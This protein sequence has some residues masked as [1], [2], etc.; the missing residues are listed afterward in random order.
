MLSAM[1]TTVTLDPDAE[2]LVRRRM[3]E[4]KVSFKQA[5]NDCI[6]EGDRRA[7]RND[8]STPSRPMGPPLVNLDKALQ[9][10]GDVEDDDII[11]KEH[12]GR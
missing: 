3:I 5:L 10:A 7:R 2:Q 11:T 6:R 4:R 8:F 12:R 9:L 1:R